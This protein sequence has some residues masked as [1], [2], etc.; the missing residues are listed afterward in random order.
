MPRRYDPGSHL[1]G[2]L[3]GSR[4]AQW[5]QPGFV[6]LIQRGTIVI[7]GATSNTATVT[8]VNVNNSQLRYLGQNGNDNLL[9]GQQTF[10]N[11]ALTNSTTITASVTTSP[12]GSTVTVSYELIEY[13]PGVIK[14]VQRGTITKPATTA[15]ITAV[16]PAKS[17]VDYLGNTTGSG[18]AISS[19]QWNY[20]TLT[21]STTVTAT[22]ANDSQIA[23]YQ[24]IELF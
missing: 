1:T 5:T 14:S 21:N 16:N 2:S 12:A 23:G 18:G 22:G 11:L 13:M 6:K 20:L 10:A 8:A 15:T 7:T 4:I 19:Q 24:V 3:L 9:T 17:V